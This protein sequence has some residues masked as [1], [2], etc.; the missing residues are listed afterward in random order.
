MYT[1]DEVKFSLKTNDCF[2]KL[3][4]DNDYYYVCYYQ[5]PNNNKELTKINWLQ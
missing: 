3:K 4:E 2:S 5:Q 1:Y